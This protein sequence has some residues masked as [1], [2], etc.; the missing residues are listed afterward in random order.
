MEVKR[1]RIFKEK[2]WRKG[3]RFR[4]GNEEWQMLG[5]MQEVCRLYGKREDDREILYERYRE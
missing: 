2:L 3:A 1:E 5:R 4:L